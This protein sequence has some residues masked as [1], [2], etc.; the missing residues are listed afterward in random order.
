MRCAGSLPLVCGDSFAVRAD[1]CSHTAVD[2]VVAVNSS[3][4]KRL[5]GGDGETYNVRLYHLGKLGFELCAAVKGNMHAICGVKCTLA[6]LKPSA[7][8]SQ[9]GHVGRSWQEPH[10]T[11]LSSPQ[12]TRMEKGHFTTPIQEVNSD[13]ICAKVDDCCSKWFVAELDRAEACKKRLL[14]DKTPLSDGITHRNPQ[15]VVE[16]M[17]PS[18]PFAD[19]APTDRQAELFRE[20]V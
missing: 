13:S 2:V 20:L 11:K 16:L 10:N 14:Q 7:A 15:R 1:R 8:E 17:G 9:S 3:A 12:H 19:C 18:G 5:A 6:A 4:T